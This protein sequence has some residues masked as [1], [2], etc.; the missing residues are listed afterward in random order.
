MVLHEGHSPY[1]GAMGKRLVLAGTVWAALGC[2]GLLDLTTEDGPAR[3]RPSSPPD[4]AAEAAAEPDG[5]EDMVL[6]DPY[7]PG[8]G[9]VDENGWPHPVR[10]SAPPPADN[11]S[12]GERQTAR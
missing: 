12:T 2:S 4:G 11:P 10:P 8:T 7:V 5:G 6:E 1:D 9:S 3:P